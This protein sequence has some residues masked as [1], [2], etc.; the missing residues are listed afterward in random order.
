MSL[1]ASRALFLSHH[2]QLG[3]YLRET[4]RQA[5]LAGDFSGRVVHPAVVHLAQLIGAFL[6]KQHHKTDVL[7]LSEDVELFNVLSALEYPAEPSTLVM[8]YIVLGEYLLFKRQIEAG[9][10]YLVKSSK[11][12]SLQDLQMSTPSLGALL[13]VGEPNE[14]T[15]EYL[16]VLAQM[17]Y[18]DKST[19]MVI[20]FTPFLDSE[21]ER[22]LK[23]LAVRRLANYRTDV[24]Y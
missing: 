17:A 19:S 23:E 15:K 4:K 11:V 3:F 6:W 13:A 16:T 18:I 7:I 22:R 2:L 12:I 20:G 14:D 24:L 8:V 5:V 10:Q 21:Y 1:S 9:R